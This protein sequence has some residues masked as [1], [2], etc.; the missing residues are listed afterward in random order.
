[1]ER[2]A[3]G[4]PTRSVAHRFTPP[5][6]LSLLLVIVV[7]VGF[8]WALLVAPFQSPDE[9]AHFAYTQSLAESFRLTGHRDLMGLSSD[10]GVA[11]AAVGAQRGQDHPS[12][13]PPDWSPADEKAYL[14]VAHSADPPSRT[15]G[16]G[17]TSASGNPPLYYLLA[18]VPYWLDHGGTVFG[19]LYA[20]RLFGVLLLALTALAAWL[21][22]GEVFG[23]RRLA[24]L[25]CGAVAALLPMA[26]FISTSVTPD[27]LLMTSWT[28]ALWLGARVIN[29]GAR[30]RDVV[31]LCVLTG[32]AVLTKATSYALV[33]PAFL[34]LLFGWLRRPQAR[35]RDGAVVISAAVVTLAAPVVAWIVLAPGLGGVSITQVGS[36]PAHPFGIRQF[37][38]Y[39][40]QFYLPRLPFMHPIRSGLP[41]YDVWVRQLIGDFG[42][43]NVFEP[44]WM[45]PVMAL[46]AGMLGV[47][48]VALLTRLRGRRVLAVLAFLGLTAL[49][50]LTLLHIT[51]YRVYI[52]GTRYFLQG[53]Y[54]LP[55]IGLLGLAVGLIVVRLPTRLRP[56]GCSVVI[57][58]LLAW[59]A[60]SL[61]SVMK[62]YYL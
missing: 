51:G 7:T 20:I 62:A 38:A 40:W 3:Q 1:M 36:S 56:I 18:G 19:R 5:T 45:Y 16:S 17:F 12:A 57:T 33:A 31:G 32:A 9:P 2:P 15:D 24:Q 50:L 22:A 14:S 10:E 11:Q 46:T 25:T 42:W 59:Q 53:R 55:L 29:H 41:A 61:V 34:A 4:P 6:P 27:A 43:L 54:L 60:I 28:F 30:H 21:L 37:I 26:T 23:T 35:R 47:A 39:V 52:T 44:S 49:A 58:W 48:S 13:S 8:S